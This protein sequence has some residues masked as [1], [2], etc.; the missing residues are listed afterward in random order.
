MK[1]IYNILK[2]L[3]T[4]LMTYCYTINEVTFKLLFPYK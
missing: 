4:V 3:F 2:R 1:Y